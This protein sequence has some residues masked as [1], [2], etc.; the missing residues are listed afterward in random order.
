MGLERRQI[1][2]PSAKFQIVRS[3]NFEDTAE[4]I[5]DNFVEE[6]GEARASYFGSF[7]PLF[8]ENEYIGQLAL[9]R[10]IFLSNQKFE[11]PSL[12]N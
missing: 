3:R 9:K 4:S 7:P 6:I 2:L 8:S 12:E 10:H 1:R 11:I 5:S